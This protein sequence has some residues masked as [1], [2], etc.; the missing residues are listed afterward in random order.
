MDEQTKQDEQKLDSTP[1][2]EQIKQESKQEPKSDLKYT[3]AD[4]DKIIER[5]FAKWQKTAF[6]SHKYFCGTRVAV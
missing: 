3:N 2:G 5:K 1:E 4:V 6:V